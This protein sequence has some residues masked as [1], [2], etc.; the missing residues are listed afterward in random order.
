MQIILF[1]L[2]LGWGAICRA[3]G[4]NGGYERMFFWNAYQVELE[5]FGPG[6][7]QIAPGCI[8][9]RPGGS[10]YF[11]EFIH[12]IG[13][14]T[15]ALDMVTPPTN[16]RPPTDATAEFLELHDMNQFFVRRNIM[17]GN[18]SFG[19]IYQSIGTRMAQAKTNAIAA[20]TLDDIKP[21]LAE[22]DYS[23]K[24]VVQGRI[25][26]FQE[27][28]LRRG[29]PDDP[30]ASKFFPYFQDELGI[31][32]Q[33]KEVRHKT[34]K[35]DKFDFRTTVANY[36]IT[37]PG[38]AQEFNTWIRRYASIDGPWAARSHYVIIKAIKIERALRNFGCG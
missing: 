33:I 8:G 32:I 15:L 1:V 37:R 17:N 34:G 12:H 22:M 6:N 24:V 25:G 2:L 4:I 11:Q 35:Y 31:Q 23:S 3:T 28:L 7:S 29:L 14:R 27:N 36:A 38:L 20:G 26:D 13:G 16:L 9:T 18:P 30:R 19:Q 21:Y 10:C 5:V